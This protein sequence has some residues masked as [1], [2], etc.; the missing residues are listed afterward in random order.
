MLIGTTSSSRDPDD[1][2]GAAVAGAE[3][4]CAWEILTPH[5]APHPL[6]IDVRRVLLLSRRR[7]SVFSSST[8][9]AAGMTNF[10][11]SPVL[12]AAGFAF[13]G[14]VVS[15]VLD[16]AAA[17]FSMWA[18]TSPTLAMSPFFFRIFVMVPAAGAGNSM[19]A[20]S[21]SMLTMFSSL[22][23]ESPSFFNHSPIS[24]SVIDSPTSGTFISVAII[25]YL[26]AS[27]KICCCSALCRLP[28]RWPGWRKQ[29]ARPRKTEICRRIFRQTSRA[30]SATRPCFP[31]PPAPKKPACRRELP[32]RR[33]ADF[34]PSMDKVAPG[35]DRHVVCFVCFAMLLQVVKNLA[36]AKQDA[37][38]LSLPLLTLVSGMHR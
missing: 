17:P 30:N 16:F 9:S 5:D 33:F 6:S 8:R 18:I 29:D 12:S 24:T 13:V 10:L 15:S 35:E 28:N 31:A 26:K 27:V 22:A 25:F 36:R 4:R 38:E 37:F 20:F 1:G 14:W 7:P 2:F 32:N 23:T 21:V 34:R 11:S 19:V 3:R